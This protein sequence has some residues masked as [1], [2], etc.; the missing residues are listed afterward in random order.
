MRGYKKTMNFCTEKNIF[1]TRLSPKLRP[2]FLEFLEELKKGPLVVQRFLRDYISQPYGG[3]E[4]D[5]PIGDFLGSMWIFRGGGDE[6][7]PSYVRIIS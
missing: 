6:K 7:L 5:F 1:F 2:G 3:L 4:D